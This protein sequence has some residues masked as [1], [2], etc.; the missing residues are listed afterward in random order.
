MLSSKTDTVRREVG[1]LDVTKFT[2]RKKMAQPKQSLESQFDQLSQELK[3]YIEWQ[4][5][6]AKE[7]NHKL[8]RIC[9]HFLSLEAL[10]KAKLVGLTTLVAM[11]IPLFLKIMTLF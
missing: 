9:T 10:I 4:N 5:E 11:F 3:I 1:F 7:I 2:S 6:A 8:D